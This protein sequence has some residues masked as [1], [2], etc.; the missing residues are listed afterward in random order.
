[1]LVF[2][3]FIRSSIVFTFSS[4]NYWTIHS[5]ADNFDHRRIW[6]AIVRNSFENCFQSKKSPRQ[7]RYYGGMVILFDSGLKKCDKSDLIIRI[8]HMLH[9]NSSG[10]LPTSP[11]QPLPRTCRTCKTKFTMNNERACVYH[12]ESFSGETAQRWLP[13]GDFRHLILFFHNVDIYSFGLPLEFHRMQ[14]TESR[15]HRDSQI[16]L[17]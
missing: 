16:H 2:I 3:K 13:P 9:L 17:S 11:V 7:Q 5:K 14:E 8:A 4:S 1:M 15:A 6:T 10:V 12:P